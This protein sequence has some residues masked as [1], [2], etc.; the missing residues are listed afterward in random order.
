MYDWIE[1]QSHQQNRLKNEEYKKPFI[2]L[3]QVTT[4]TN[5][6]AFKRFNHYWQYGAKNFFN[7]TLHQQS[8]ACADHSE[9]DTDLKLIKR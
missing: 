6:F 7:L 9:D 1:N 4:Y 2:N 8:D 5:H 3:A